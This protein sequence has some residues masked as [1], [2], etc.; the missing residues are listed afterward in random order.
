MNKK[1][2]LFIYFFYHLGKRVYNLNLCHHFRSNVISK[3]V[4]MNLCR[5]LVLIWRQPQEFPLK[6][7]TQRTKKKQQRM[8]CDWVSVNAG[9]SGLIH[10]KYRIMLQIAARKD[11]CSLVPRTQTPTTSESELSYL[12]WKTFQIWARAKN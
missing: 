6:Q 11:E 8:G 9:I 12:K 7:K 1:E 2:W 3:F 5:F 10:K 4:F